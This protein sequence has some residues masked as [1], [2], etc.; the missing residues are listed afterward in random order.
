MAN[1]R[2]SIFILPVL[3]LA[4]IFMPARA[5]DYLQ[6]GFPAE[7][8]DPVIRISSGNAGYGRPINIEGM[9]YNFAPTFFIYPDHTL[10]DDE[11]D[12]LVDEL[13]IR[14][15]K[16]ITY[17]GIYVINPTS[18]KYDADS[19]FELFKEMAY[20]ASFTGNLKVIGIDGGAT[21]VNGVIA[22]RA[23][24]CIA[25]ILSINGKK[26]KLPKGTYAGVPAYIYGA[27]AA[28]VAQAYIN[29]A[30]AV[31]QDGCFTRPGEPLMKVVAD[32][33]D[34]KSLS[35]V[36]D[37]AWKSVLGRNYRFNNSKHTHYD[38]TPFGEYGTFE[39]EPYLDTKSLGIVRLTCESAPNNARPSD[40]WLWYEYWPEELMD[41]GAERSVPVVI[42]LHG[43]MNDPRTQ[44]ETSGFLQL[45][46]KE[47]FFVAELEWQG[48]NAYAA[49]QHDGIEQVVLG[50]LKKYPQLDPSRVYA[51]GLSAG[52]ITAT[53][54]GIE[55]S[56]IFAA[57]GGNSGGVFFIERDG[58]FSTYNSLWAKATQKRG[59][60]IMPY[61]SVLGMSDM[62]VPFYNK[63]NY[64]E[65]GYL[66]AWNLY[67]QMAGLD[68]I[69]TL[70]YSK[71]DLFGI[72]LTDR[73]TVKVKR[74]SDFTIETGL[75]CKEDIP[76][77]K[78][79][80]IRDYG[81]WN[82]PPATAMMWEFFKHFS[83]DPQTYELMYK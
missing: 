10:T 5:E 2:K 14:Q 52:S 69:R 27:D 49:M 47:R 79:I 28:K 58:M 31:Q 24:H 22:P 48:N 45:A 32:S 33:A 8:P 60:V 67:M 65:N 34:G 78:I 62:I 57:V 81:H 35:E 18:G 9:S 4:S 51:Q 44:A 21:F 7:L 53:A 71:D 37:D 77:V 73:Q 15:R 1:F 11:A 42:L 38:G 76:V 82:F 25:G 30:G 56:H 74:E 50:L 63:D 46:A 13:G 41:G 16:D 17:G 70:D 6:Q 61:C 12:R 54:I 66:N 72:E 23:C 43:N 75:I 29:R 68:P 26:C 64:K 83:R 36:F 39:L 20:M 59:N 19:D 55:K 40:K 80:A 3:L